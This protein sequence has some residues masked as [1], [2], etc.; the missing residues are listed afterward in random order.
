MNPC[1]YSGVNE[2]C[3]NGALYFLLNTS[4]NITYTDKIVVIQSFLYLIL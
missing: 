1:D 2:I 4:F 3:E